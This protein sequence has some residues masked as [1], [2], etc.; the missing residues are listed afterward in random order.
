MRFYVTHSIQQAERN[1]TDEQS[2]EPD[3]FVGR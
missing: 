2:E 1:V 3:Y